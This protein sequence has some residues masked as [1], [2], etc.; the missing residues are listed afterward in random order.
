MIFVWLQWM[1][2]SRRLKRRYC[3]NNNKIFTSI[4]SNGIKEDQALFSVDDI[5]DGFL[6]NYDDYKINEMKFNTQGAPL[7][8]NVISNTVM[9]GGFVFEVLEFKVLP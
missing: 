9:D 3:R 5:Y 7:K 4:I 8:L 6:S 2:M 1:D